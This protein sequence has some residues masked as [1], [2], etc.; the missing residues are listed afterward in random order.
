M[1]CG[2]D[3]QS[4]LGQGILSVPNSVQSLPHEV[5]KSLPS[6]PISRGLRPRLGVLNRN[7]KF[8]RTR[9]QVALALQNSFLAAAFLCG[10]IHAADEA[11]TATFR[12]Y[13]FGCHSKAASMGGIN[14]EQ[15]TSQSSLGE[16]FQKWQKVAAMLEQKR[17]PPAKMKQPTDEE[18]TAAATWIHTRLNE[19]IA[20]N[21]GDPGRVTVRRLTSGEYAYAVQD[22]TGL[23]LKFDRDFANDAVGGEGFTNFGDVQFMADAGLERYLETAKRVADHAVIGAGPLFF[24]DD[25]GKSGFELSAISRI[26]AIYRANGFRSNSGEGGKPFGMERVSQAFF[27]CWRYKNRAALGEPSATLESIA[28]REGVSPRFANH[29]WK[30]LS[31]RDATYPT[32]EVLKVF[33]SLPATDV[34]AARKGSEDV[35]RAMIG[36]P[37]WLLAAGAEAEGGD[38]DE[39]ALVLTD[40]SL[41]AVTSFHFKYGVRA[42]PN[43]PARLYLSALSAL[44]DDKH[45]PVLWRNGTVRVRGK[46]KGLSG[47]QPLKAYL[48]AAT[49]QKLGDPNEFRGEGV[50]VL[51]LQLPEGA[52]GAELQ[53]DAQLAPGTSQDAVLRTTISDAEEV[54][55]GRPM[56]ALL[57]DAKSPVY[58]EWKKN[59][60][61]YDRLLPMNSQGEPAPADKDPIPPPYNDARN[62]PERD[63]YH[64]KVK[65]YRKDNFLLEHIL[66]D[67]TRVKLDQAWADLLASFEYHD[68][69]LQFTKT[70]YKLDLTKAHVADL[71]AADIASIQA[72]PRKYIQDL[73]TSW[74]AVQKAQLSAR[75]RH[76]DDCLDFAA[77]AWRRPLTQPEK[78]RLRY[79][80]VRATEEQKL[81]HGKAIELVL[82]R[83]LVS[84]AFLYRLEQPAQTAAPKALSDWEIASRLSFFLWSSLPDQE[85]RRA[86][87]AGELKTDEGLRRQVKRMVADD[88][89]RRLATEF[90]G[91]WLGFYHF[92]QHK[93]VDAKRFPEF[94]DDVKN[95]MYEEAISFFDYIVRNGRPV[96]EML[97]ANYTFLTPALAKHYGI[98]KDINTPQMV[99]G[100]NE[101]QRGGMLRLGAV[102]TATSAPLRTSPVKRGDWVLRRILGTPTPPP[103]ADAGSIPAD[104]K[105]FGGLS[106]KQRLEVHKRNATCASCHTRI[107]PLGFPLE[108]YDSV[109][110]WR[111][112]YSDGK[113]V[114]DTSELQDKTQIAGVE[115]LLKYLGTQQSQVLKTMSYKL[116]GYALGRTVQA[117]DQPLIDKLTSAGGDA[118]FANLV[119]E[120]VTSKQFR[121]RREQP[122]V[123]KP[124]PQT[125]L[126]AVPPVKTNKEG[127]E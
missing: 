75:P 69:I 33:N 24:F 67:A 111:Q 53:I 57:A 65:Y 76:I 47:T 17:M 64:T 120:I 13:C 10:T 52:L 50:V 1:K 59:V 25:P 78:D 90:F 104:D 82:A 41:A 46:Q 117:S 108:H 113:A 99:Q 124:S 103:P 127:G 123:P 121:Y 20:K 3:N 80:Y 66:D 126:T 12:Q 77:R 84:P 81:D 54:S 97:D 2:R 38:G 22:L 11:P 4:G 27:V 35:M 42:R 26:N 102:L 39:R 72:E 30:V 62:Q 31:L 56:W 101:F 100:A 125:K 119:A 105:L 23:D 18:R 115:G 107:D 40:K 71:T 37:R 6:A 68:T 44:G 14:L 45:Y 122:D 48:D 60:L 109:G 36:W 118:T 15:L 32:T 89:S 70:K 74:D 95:G 19:F 61:E 86:A 110:R 93:G 114:D 43:K 28:A 34:A 63:Q 21:A 112:T 7:M 8:L 87:G 55:K 88:R 83:I 58:L 16:S 106:V 91:Q 73:R 85:L 51:E 98:R 116:V 5:T 94:T 96:H 29:L 79:F 49:V 92:D 9:R